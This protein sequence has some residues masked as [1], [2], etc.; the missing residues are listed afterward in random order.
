VGKWAFTF[1]ILLL[2]VLFTKSNLQLIKDLGK[3][4]SFLF[5]KRQEEE[6]EEEEVTYLARDEGLDY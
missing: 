5:Q 6:E 4:F 2:L 3:L 1:L